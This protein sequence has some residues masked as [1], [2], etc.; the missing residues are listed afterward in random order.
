MTL[1]LLLRVRRRPFGIVVLGLHKA[2]NWRRNLILV[3]LRRHVAIFPTP[4]WGG[5]EG[6][7]WPCHTV[8][9]SARWPSSL[10]HRFFLFL[11]KQLS[12]NSPRPKIRKIQD[13]Y[14]HKVIFT[15]WGPLGG[16]AA[17]TCSLEMLRGPWNLVFISRDVRGSV[18]LNAPLIR[19]G[20]G[21]FQGLVNFVLFCFF[22]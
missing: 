22:M 7:P 1:S 15:W 10:P 4:P 19:A 21:P 3:S 12:S 2:W 13:L 17:P 20:P 18:D 14:Y 16:K 9:V 5:G 11:W 6:G 8:G